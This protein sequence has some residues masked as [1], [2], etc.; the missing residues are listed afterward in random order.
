MSQPIGSSLDAAER[1]A[2]RLETA[3]RR[4]EAGDRTGRTGVQR[5]DELGH[6]ARALDELAERLDQLERERTSC[7]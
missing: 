4:L 2:T 3:L 5:A 6:V 1:D 7:E